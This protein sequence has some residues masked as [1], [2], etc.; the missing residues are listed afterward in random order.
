GPVS[1]QAAGAALIKELQQM[2]LTIPRRFGM[3]VALSVTVCVVAIA[4]QLLVTR[5]ALVDE[6]K[7]AI[8]AQVQSAVAILREFAT[9]AEKGQLTEAEAQTRAKAVLR[10]IRYG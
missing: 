10:A 7:N 1:R 5:A 2:I 6:R 8:A 4:S 9:A 3:L